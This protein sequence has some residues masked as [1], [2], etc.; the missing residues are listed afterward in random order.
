MIS[1]GGTELDLYAFVKNR[2]PELPAVRSLAFSRC[3]TIGVGGS[4]AV[5]VSPRTVEEAAELLCVLLRERIPHYFLGAGANIL[6]PDGEYEGVIVRFSALNALYADGTEVYCGAGVTGGA[7]CRFARA[8]LL[9]GAECFTGIPMTV[10]GGIAMNAGVRDGHFSDLV[11]RVVALDRGRIAVLGK[12]DCLFGNKRSVFQGGI[13]VLGASLMLRYSYREEI[14]RNTC[15]FRMR[16]KDLPKGRSMGC[17]FVNP[18][19]ESAGEL[20]DRCGL[21]GARIGGAFV[22][23]AHANFIISDG[24]SSADVSALIAFVR[25]QVYAQTGVLLREEIRRI[26]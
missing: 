21:K 4:A 10:G 17:V 11:C 7:L 22:S 5:A 15:Y 25:K 8:R 18:E 1:Y 12:G 26:V 20:I 19:G 16:R 23:S 9:S 2:F 3:T 13:A 24:G 6:P 14:E